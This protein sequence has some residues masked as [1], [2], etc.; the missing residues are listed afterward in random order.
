MP[1]Q[2][3]GN[4]EATKAATK[5]TKASAKATKATAKKSETTV[6]QVMTDGVHRVHTSASLNEV[7]Q[8]MWDHDIGVVPVV[9]T[10]DRLKGVV[11]D[12]DIAM[13]AYLKNR[14]PQNV[15]VQ[16][17]MSIDVKTV[18]PVDTL[19]H[20]ASTMADHQ[21]RRLPVVDDEGQL[22]GMLSLNDLAE[23]SGKPKP[24]GI[25]KQKVADTLRAICAPHVASGHP[26]V[27]ATSR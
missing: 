27:S 23:V 16:E 10:D 20:A 25:S 8:R 3:R 13:A 22:I 12:R 17:V 11:T 15:G 18:R 4:V 24:D 19:S 2:S 6:A 26:E 7:A 9:D 5:A 21:I 14:S 1:E